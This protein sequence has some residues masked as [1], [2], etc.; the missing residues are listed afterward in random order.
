M[1]AVRERGSIQFNSDM[2][3]REFKRH[4]ALHRWIAEHELRAG[5]RQAPI[6]QQDQM[7]SEAIEGEAH[8]LS[9]WTL[10]FLERPF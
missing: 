9:S 2:T 4:A 1:R 7:L 10:F 5:W 6:E 3:V 8:F